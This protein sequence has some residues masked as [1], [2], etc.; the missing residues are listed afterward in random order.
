MVFMFKA[1]TESNVFKM[2]FNFLTFVNKFKFT[3]DVP[4][5]FSLMKSENKVVFLES[6][7]FV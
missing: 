5:L 4:D 2:V 1:L 3:Q 7:L 6:Y